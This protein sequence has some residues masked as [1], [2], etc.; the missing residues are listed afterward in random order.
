MKD[1][2]PENATLEQ[3]LAQIPQGVWYSII[4][5]SEGDFLISNVENREF[6]NDL[7]LILKKKKK[8]H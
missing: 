7:F 8:E 4:W 2:K 6:L 5:D 1:T 3:L